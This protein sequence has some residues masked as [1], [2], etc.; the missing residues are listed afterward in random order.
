[1]EFSGVTACTKLFGAP[2][3]NFGGIIHRKEARLRLQKLLPDTE[4]YSKLQNALLK[5]GGIVEISLR[6][7]SYKVDTSVQ[8][9]LGGFG[10]SE[11]LAIGKA[12]DLHGVGE[13]PLFFRGV[14]PIYFSHIVALAGDFYAAVGE[15]ISLPGGDD[16][17][18]TDRFKNAFNSLTNANNNQIRRIILEIDHEYASVRH[19]GL[20]H[21]CYSSQLM[22]KSRTLKKIKGD[23][24]ELLINNSDHFSIHAQDA[25]R[26]GHA[27]AIEVA[28]LAGDQQDLE[29]LKKAYAIDAFA[30]H[31]LTD[32]FAAGHIRNQRG[33]LEIFLCKLGF[34]P[35][36]AKP[37]AGLLTAAQHE[38][39]GHDGLNVQ[40]QQGEV[41]RAYGDGCYWTPQ[42]ETNITQVVKA[43]QHSVDEIYSFYQHP[44]RPLPNI[45]SPWIPKVME[46][47]P[48]P[49][50]FV[51][52]NCTE[53]FLHEGSK[54]IKIENRKDFLAKGISHALRYLPE[55]YITSYIDSFIR[56]PNFDI[57]L[58]NKVVVPQIERLTGTVWHILGVASH[59][60][61]RQEG[62][63][64][65]AKI[66]EMS[67]GLR[68]TT[69]KTTMILQ[70]LERIESQIHQQVVDRI[71]QDLR[72]PILD[73]EKGILEFDNYVMAQNNDENLQEM[74]RRLWNA[75]LTIATVLIQRTTSSG[76]RILTAYKAILDPSLSA[77]EVTIS[78]T[79]WFRQM[80]DYQIKAFNL[81]AALWAFRNQA[82]Q[83]N[84]Q[85]ASFE[86]LLCKQIEANKHDINED[87]IYE[88]ANYISMQQAKSRMKQQA[89]EF[90]TGEI[91][92]G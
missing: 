3:S 61:V 9:I 71:F 35:E 87:L 88:S 64:L 26:I 16:R 18:K 75:H 21:H 22:E 72:E 39:D 46:C 27:Y 25:Y 19:S 20:P 70:Q 57:P 41:W 36:K 90:F 91:G 44:K 30:C 32:L 89:L 68:V 11:H 47:N 37:L 51:N 10:S 69:E 34:S 15:A 53:L 81:W 73:I 78:V 82:V 12:V 59:Y 28:K 63:L 23:I 14:T 65:N 77:E 29:G 67:K 85:V 92:N 76:K 7:N 84:A 55:S 60:Q 56:T 2:Y 49:V 80:L 52:E 62:E 33:Q 1:M 5:T 4:E 8:S 6:G 13:A 31:F 48:L 42:N 79:L 58:L 74:Q 54:V 83:L 86:A 45:P 17:E 38:K 66:E 40:N 24:D 43:T 50:Y